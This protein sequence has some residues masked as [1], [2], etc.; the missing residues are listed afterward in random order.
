MNVEQ[1]KND[2]RMP[3]HIAFIIDGNGR[4]AKKR[5]L[6]RSFGHEVG[7]QNVEKTIQNVKE[8]GI[9]NVTFYCFS[10]ENWNRPK[11]EVDFLMTKF[12]EMFDE[13][14][15]KYSNENIRI[16]ISG[17]MEDERLPENVRI[18]SRNL[19]QKTKNNNEFI[20]NMCINYGGRQEIL[21]AVNEIIES[22]E[23]NIDEKAFEKHLYTAELFPVDFIVRTSGEQRT[24][25]F[26]P[27]QSTY[28]EWYFPKKH[29]PAFSKK[30]L[31]K[32]I[33]IYMKRNR[34]FGAIKG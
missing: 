21:K 34:R 27:W 26:L 19:M 8:L 20:I 5:G 4:W 18:K 11:E 2:R 3:K 28:S 22:G 25:N 12:D 1:L 10:S 9:K 14:D 31:I 7:S 30:D 16:I 15:K 32:A 6:P 24:S 13:Y 33:K 17:N 23:K 29:W